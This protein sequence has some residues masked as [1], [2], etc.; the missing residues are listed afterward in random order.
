M[1]LAV[2]NLCLLEA[3]AGMFSASK[4]CGSGSKP[5]PVKKAENKD[6]N[7]LKKQLK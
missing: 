5:E 2:S 4:Y 6:R 7:N 3:G 1:I